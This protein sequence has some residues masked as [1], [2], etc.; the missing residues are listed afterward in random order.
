MLV[1]VDPFKTEVTT[2]LIVRLSC[3]FNRL[4]NEK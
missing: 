4:N 2:T 3:H 1:V